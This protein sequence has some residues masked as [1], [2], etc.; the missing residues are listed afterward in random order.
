MIPTLQE[1]KADLNGS[2]IFSK[3]DLASGYHQLQLHEDSRYITCFATHIGLFVYKRLNFGICCASEIFLNAIAQVLRGLTD[4][5]NISDDILIYA[6]SVEI[7]NATLRA[8]LKRLS[9][10]GLTLNKQKCELNKREIKFFGYIF[11]D[12]GVSVDPRRVEIIRILEPP[13]RS[14]EHTSELGMVTYMSSHIPDL[15]TT[16]EPLRQLT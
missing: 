9:E 12:H 5:I 2:I 7:H 6:P 16:S 8:V 13:T 3:L 11:S 14:E 15:A 10:H 4:V 1:L